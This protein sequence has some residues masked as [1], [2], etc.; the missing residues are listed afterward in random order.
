MP[1]LRTTLT[2]SGSS[3]GDLRRVF[4]IMVAASHQC[5]GM[6]TGKQIRPV[7]QETAWG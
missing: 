3:G 6:N 7:L 5:L 1:V 2:S 4:P